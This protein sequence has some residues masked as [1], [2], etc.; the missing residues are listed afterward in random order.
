MLT[1][2]IVRILTTESAAGSRLTYEKELLDSR[3]NSHFYKTNHSG[4]AASVCQ[5]SP[6]VKI[7]GKPTKRIVCTLRGKCAEGNRLTYEKEPPNS[8]ETSHS[9]KTNHPG[10]PATVAHATPVKWDIPKC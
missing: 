9:Y 5:P 10:F 4:F 3:K 8:W 6:L 7:N 1:K 2:R